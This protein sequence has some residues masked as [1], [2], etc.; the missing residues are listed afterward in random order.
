MP[1]SWLIDWFSNVGDVVSNMSMNAVDN[2]VTNYSF[3]MRRESWEQSASVITWHE[4][5]D[6]FGGSP[7]SKSSSSLG[8]WWKA[9]RGSY[10][11]TER[12]EIKS[13]VGGGN[14]FGLDV[15]LPSLSGRQLAIL[16]AL[17]ISRQ[18]VL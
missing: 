1:Y 7:P 13:R 15:S 3:V 4:K 17:G 2:L 9:H 5:R 18:S 14:P 6:D 16:A 10:S 8:S 11:S 12:W